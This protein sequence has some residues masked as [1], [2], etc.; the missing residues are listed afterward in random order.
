MSV[1]SALIR[2]VIQCAAVEETGSWRKLGLVTVFLILGSSNPVAVKAAFMLGWPP[3]ILG[4]MRM[5]FIGL[6]FLG[7]SRL[8]KEH[9]FGPNQKARRFALIAAA[10]KG[11]G[12][13]IK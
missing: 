11:L 1:V 6:F 4:I 8:A 13:V 12:D 2:K 9:P 5:G 3:L 7:W 10:C